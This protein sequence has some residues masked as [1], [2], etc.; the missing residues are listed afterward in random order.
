MQKVF[1]YNEVLTK[2]DPLL[3]EARGLLERKSS[4]YPL[5]KTRMSVALPVDDNLTR[6]EMIYDVIIFF[7]RAYRVEET[8]NV[9]IGIFCY[10]STMRERM[11]VGIFHSCWLSGNLKS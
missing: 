3:I 9:Y 11:Y 6:L 4:R 1:I 8:W 7:T 5:N 10:F 2:L